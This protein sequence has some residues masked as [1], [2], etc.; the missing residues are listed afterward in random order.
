MAGAW[1]ADSNPCEGMTPGDRTWEDRSITFN[2][3]D[4]NEGAEWVKTKTPG[5]Q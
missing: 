3:A 1:G 4:Y 2:V 5:K